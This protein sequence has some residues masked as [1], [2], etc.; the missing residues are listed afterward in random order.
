VRVTTIFLATIGATTVVLYINR[1]TNLQTIS[2][3]IE[4]D[5]FTNDFSYRLVSLSDYH[6]H[7]LNYQN[8]SLKEA[9]EKESPDAVM[10]TGDMVD[11]HT[12]ADNLSVLESLVSF[13]KEKAY[14]TFFVSGNHEEDASEE[15]RNASYSIYEKYG[16]K[17]LQP[18]DN[19]A[20]LAK[21]NGVSL[22]IFGFRDPGLNEKDKTGLIEGSAINK[23]AKAMN[24]DQKNFNLLLS[25][26]PS[27]FEVAKQKGFDLT[28]SG[29]THAGQI[30]IFGY[31]LLSWPW[32]KYERG[33]YLEEGKRL[34]ISNGL[35]ESFYLPF[36][37][38]CPYTLLSI[39]IRGT[40]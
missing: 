21:N 23:Q 28:L 36:R 4:T 39:T 19:T 16:I 31:P 17:I 6:N 13:F 37:F 1:E 22:Q 9:I 34:I 7:G 25:H 27:F 40:R 10:M 2:Y 12:N 24:L 32:T 3:T 29:H 26:Q 30:D 15:I 5:K 33:T 14:P 20:L 18:E 8:E 11:S 38:N 35:G